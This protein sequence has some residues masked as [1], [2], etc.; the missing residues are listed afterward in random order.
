MPSGDIVNLVFKFVK[1]SV[2]FSIR[3]LV[4]AISA[5]AAFFKLFENM[6][7]LFTMT[8]LYFYALRTFPSTSF[9]T[10]D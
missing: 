6:F 4:D 1:L 10:V 7:A 2:S 8:S 5:S 9:F 3:C